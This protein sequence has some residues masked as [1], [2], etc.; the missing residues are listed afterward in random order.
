MPAKKT[1]VD[2]ST[3]TQHTPLSHRKFDDASLSAQPDARIGINPER[4]FT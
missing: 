4:V 1:V 3:A 2:P